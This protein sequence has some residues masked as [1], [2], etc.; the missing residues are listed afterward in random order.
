[1]DMGEWLQLGVA[2]GWCSE[3][4]CDTHEG[5]PS[6]DAEF[7]DWEQGFDPCVPAVRLYEQE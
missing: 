4:V 5:L 7:A 2:R 3:V 1:M 6:T